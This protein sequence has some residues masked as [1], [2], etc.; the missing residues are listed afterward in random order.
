M[1]G[2]KIQIQMRSKCQDQW[3]GDVDGSIK[4]MRTGQACRDDF[5][6]RSAQMYDVVDSQEDSHLVGV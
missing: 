4:G 2:V 1:P 3:T 5:R 6:R